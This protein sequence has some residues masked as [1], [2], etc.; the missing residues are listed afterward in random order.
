MLASGSAKRCVGQKLMPPG[1]NVATAMSAAVNRCRGSVDVKQCGWRGGSNRGRLPK[2]MDRET[3]SCSATDRLRRWR[4]MSL[5]D[6]CSL[7]TSA[8]SLVR[9]PCVSTST[10]SCRRSRAHRCRIGGGFVPAVGLAQQVAG[11]SPDPAHLAASTSLQSVVQEGRRDSGRARRSPMP[12]L[13]CTCALMNNWKVVHCRSFT[14][15]GVE[16]LGVTTTDYSYHRAPAADLVI[17]ANAA[18]LIVHC[19]PGLLDEL[20]D[21]PAGGERDAQHRHASRIEKPRRTGQAHRSYG[22]SPAR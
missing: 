18:T 21:R 17:Q 4:T 16:V 19:S 10:R 22:D 14:K 5:F 20:D 15:K 1:A 11:S 13:N 3:A 6:D 7:G 2:E 9:G 8:S 12:S